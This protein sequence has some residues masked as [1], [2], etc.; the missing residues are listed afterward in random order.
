MA[1]MHISAHILMLNFHIH[2]EPNPPANLSG[3]MTCDSQ[4][5]K[6]YIEWKVYIPY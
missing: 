3:T 4:D 6:V 2:A 5:Y 1:C